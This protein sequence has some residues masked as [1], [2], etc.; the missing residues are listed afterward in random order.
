MCGRIYQTIYNVRL[1]FLAY[2]CQV[3]RVVVDGIHRALATV[4]IAAMGALGIVVD[5]PGIKI[6]LEVFRTGIEVLAQG[7]L[8]ELRPDRAVEALDEAIGLGAA[9]LGATVLHVVERQIEFEGMGVRA[10]E[11]AAVVG[12]DG[13]H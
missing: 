6:G 1:T 10:T 4:A 13:A 5:E 3:V 11:L 2:R 9:H 8:E 12:Q 7:D